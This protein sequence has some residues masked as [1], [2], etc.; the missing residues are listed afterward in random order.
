MK[1]RA[2]ALV[3]AV[4]TLMRSEYPEASHAREGVACSSARVQRVFV[5]VA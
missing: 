2:V 5:F 4:R 1:M 3:D